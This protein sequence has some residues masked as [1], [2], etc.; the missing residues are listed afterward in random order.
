MKRELKII[1]SVVLILLSIIVISAVLAYLK[2]YRNLIHGISNSYITIM[3]ISSIIFSSSFLY[4][5]FSRLG[6][7]QIS[8]QK[9]VI[10]FL[11]VMGFSLFSSLVFFFLGNSFFVK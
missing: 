3:T 8:G 9:A 11:F 1:L 2:N 10:Y 4:L 5:L 6:T 7:V